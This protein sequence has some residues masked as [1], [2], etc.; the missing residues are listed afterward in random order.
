[1][2]ILLVAAGLVAL[3]SCSYMYEVTFNITI[4]AG[5]AGTLVMEADPEGRERVPIV[6]GTTRYQAVVGVCCAPEPVVTL[7]A[8]IDADGNGVH[9]ASE[10]MAVDPA[11]AVV[12]SAN[13]SIALS[14]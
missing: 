3:S 5:A 2:R 10:P 8:F 7:R 11:G 9:D 13:R 14:L 4:P 6:P 12:L 1:M